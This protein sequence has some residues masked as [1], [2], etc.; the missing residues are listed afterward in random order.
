MRHNT[1]SGIR[2]KTWFMAAGLLVMLCSVAIAGGRG[3]KSKTTISREFYEGRELFV[4]TWEPGEPSPIGGDG[5]GPLYNEQSCVACHHL[6]GVGG[7]GGTIS[8]SAWLRRSPAR[9]TRSV[10]VK[11]SWAS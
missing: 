9:A 11:C 2:G 3:S 4:K 6:G 7:A 10:A 8:M 1:T 5:L